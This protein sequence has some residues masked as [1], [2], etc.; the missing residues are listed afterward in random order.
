MDRDSLVPMG[1]AAGAFGLK[2]E[3]KVSSHASGPEVFERAGVFYA[4][5][6]PGR[7]KPYHLESLRPHGGRLLFR[8]REIKTREQ[9]A[10]LGGAFIYLLRSDLPEA[11][12]D[13]YYWFELKGCQ[14]FLPSGRQLGTLRGIVDTGGHELWVIKDSDGRE[15]I[16]PAIEN[17]VLEM[18]LKARR[19]VVDPPPGLLETQGWPPE[20]EG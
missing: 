15:A 7:A 19:L 8:V 10:A 12:P 9:A 11:A 4:G 13:E 1:R 17:V 3:L 16:I 18:D 20:F 5:A 6:D 14:V 2:G